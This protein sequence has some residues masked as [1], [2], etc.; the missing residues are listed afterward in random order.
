MSTSYCTYHSE[1]KTDISLTGD[2]TGSVDFNKGVRVHLH[3]YKVLSV[4]KT[5]RVSA[6]FGCKGRFVS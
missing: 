5:L 1:R 6:F 2:D 4:Y 3:V